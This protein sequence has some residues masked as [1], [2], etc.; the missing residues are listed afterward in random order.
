M[1]DETDAKP[2]LT[3]E[4]ERALDQARDQGDARTARKLEAITEA[5]RTGDVRALAAVLLGMGRT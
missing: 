2:W 1:R 3:R 4:L 5:Q